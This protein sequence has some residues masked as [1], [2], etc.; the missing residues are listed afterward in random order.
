MPRA[1]SVSFQMSTRWMLTRNWASAGLVSVKSS[2]PSRT[3]LDELLEAG[4]DDQPDGPAHQEEH[5][6]QREHLV[7]R[8][9]PEVAR[10]GEDDRQARDGGAQLQR[11]FEELDEEVR[12]VGELAHD[13][14]PEECPQE[15]EV[16]HALTILMRLPPSTPARPRATPG[17][18]ATGRGH[19]QAACTPSPS[20][21]CGKLTRPSSSSTGKLVVHRKGSIGGNDLQRPGQEGEGRHLARR[22]TAGQ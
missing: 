16:P 2:V 18:A 4:L 21:A 22:E 10:V 3:R 12:P 8:P 6:H 9:A 1:T 11:R 5:P 20:R 7:R 19:S 15:P 13:A 17:A 14:D